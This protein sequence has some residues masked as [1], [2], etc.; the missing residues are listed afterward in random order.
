ME[1]HPID[2]L[3]ELTGHIPFA[4]LVTGAGGDPDGRLTGRPLMVAHPT[5]DEP[6]DDDPSVFWFVVD[7]GVSWAPRR[8]TI[9]E[10]CL[11]LAD[12]ARQ[13]VVSVSGTAT[14]VADP[15]LVDQ[16]WEPPLAE[17]LPHPDGAIALRVEADAYSWWEGPGPQVIRSVEVRRQDLDGRVRHGHAEL[18]SALTSR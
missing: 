16:M 2:L 11:V 10:V 4:V 3:D 12:E 6:S 18:A 14:S 15:E 9:A 8:G 7:P 13:R 1:P 5:G 17:W